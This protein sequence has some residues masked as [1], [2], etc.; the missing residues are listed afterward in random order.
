M[1]GR[2]RKKGLFGSTVAQ[3]CAHCRHNGGRQGEKPLCTLRL[4][5]E[6]GKC[7][8]YAYDPLRREPRRAPT[9]PREDYSEADFK[10]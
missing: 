2:K 4:E 3:D 9:L 7:K 5:P 8:K 1:F 6:N 10:L